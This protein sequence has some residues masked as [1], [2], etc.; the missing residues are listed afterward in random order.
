AASGAAP[1][2]PSPEASWQRA[3]DVLVEAGRAADAPQP[4]AE[5]LADLA[6][7]YEKQLKDV[8]RAEAT[9]QQVVDLDPEDPVLV[10]PATRALERI[11]QAAGKS[12]ELASALRA[13]VKLEESVDARRTLFA[14]LG[15]LCEKTLDDPRGAT[16]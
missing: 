16:L 10:L 1:A 8:A 3:A 13:Q 9:W 4:R 6:R 7:L 12:V 15:E 5:I 14:R 2:Q 11:Y